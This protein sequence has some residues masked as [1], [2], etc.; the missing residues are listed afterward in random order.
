V[1]DC[2]FKDA[3]GRQWNLNL[4]LG[5]ARRIDTMNFDT[6]YESKW[7]FIR[8]EKEV[9][10]A[11]VSDNSF[12]FAV[13]WA[14]VVDQAKAYFLEGTFLPRASDHDLSPEER[15]KNLDAAF[16][17]AKNA[18]EELSPYEYAELEFASNIDGR[19]IEDGRTAFWRSLS[20]FFQD[21]KTVLE[22]LMRQY[23]NLRS[24]IDASVAKLEPEIQASLEKSLA[25]D[26]SGVR[27]KLEKLTQEE[28][29][30]VT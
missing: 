30:G 25:K 4:H 10:S 5:I 15:K 18:G 3:K 28:R 26:M 9:F 24:S 8:P 11:M 2:T 17:T 27:L 23:K 6:Y 13:I 29:V 19:S 20:T 16:S 21:Q 22:V 14:I 12:M 7:S 1:E